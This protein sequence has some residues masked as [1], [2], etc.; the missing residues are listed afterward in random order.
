MA[1]M[2]RHWVADPSS[3]AYLPDQLSSLEYRLMLDVSPEEMDVLLERGWRRFGPAYFR[4]ACSACRACVPLRIPVDTF[5]PTKSQRRVLKRAEALRLRI[6]PPEV[7]GARLALY[8]RW[9]SMQSESRGWADDR[10]TGDEYYQQFAFPHPCVREYAYFDDASDG[11]PRLIAVAIVDETP[12]ALSAVYTYHDPDYRR[13]SLGT[14]SI[15]RQVQQAQRSG[16]RWL[17]LGYRVLGCP[18]SEY[19]SRYRPH[20][21]LAG[22]PEFGERPRWT[23]IQSTHSTELAGPGAIESSES[24]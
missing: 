22:F 13:W 2:L 11:G 16:R 3:C 14:L 21:L 18:S 5:T 19:K 4:P 6:G 1:R 9:H 20:E 10:I 8:H 17:Y 23:A 24:E 7:D 15:L 12:Q